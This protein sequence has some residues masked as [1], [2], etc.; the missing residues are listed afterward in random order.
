MRLRSSD[1]GTALSLGLITVLFTFTASCDDDDGAGGGGD[2]GTDTDADTDT[3]TDSA[4]DSE[5]GDGC[6]TDAGCTGALEWM[7]T[8]SD[9]Y[10]AIHAGGRIAALPD[11][12]SLVFGRMSEPLTLGV[13]EPNETTISGSYQLF[14]ARFAPAGSLVWAKGAGGSNF[15]VER[16]IAALPDGSFYT[17]GQFDDVTGVFGAGEPNETILSA[18]GA[19]DV[20]VAK[21][22]ADG[23]LVWAKRAGGPGTAASGYGEDDH[24]YGA[25]A[26]DDGTVAIIGYFYGQAVFGAGESNE[27][28]LESG[29]EGY[30]SYF[31]AEYHPDGDFA[32]ARHLD[33]GNGNPDGIAMASDGSA[34]ITGLLSGMVVFGEGEPNETTLDAGASINVFVAKLATDGS[35]DWAKLVGPAYTGGGPGISAFP[36]GSMLV[37]SSFEGTATFGEE[38]ENETVLESVGMDDAFLAKLSCDG[39]LVWVKSAGGSGCIAYGFEIE[40]LD[41]GSSVFGGEY[42]FAP[43]VFGA[44]EPNETTLASPEQSS[45]DDPGYLNMFIAKYDAEG[46]LTWA[47]TAG[48]DHNA[49]NGALSTACDG[50]TLVAATDSAPNSSD[51]YDFLA[52]YRP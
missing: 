42:R 8:I 3:D 14:V 15:R 20:F 12:S 45:S 4:V 19:H 41:D 46:S 35:L 7:K 2:A 36:D 44:G 32:W 9:S 26:A 43:I 38:Q 10:S 37:V 33:V 18:L 48:S 28:T 17:T 25:S 24:S 29:G 49:A 52:R 11:G 13:G 40:A 47:T 51:V 30:Y 27:T 21:Y 31:V 6:E 39:D 34:L 1:L 16:G 50:S 23:S 5:C 22:A